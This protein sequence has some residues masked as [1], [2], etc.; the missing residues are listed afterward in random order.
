MKRFHHKFTLPLI[1]TLLVLALAA[2]FIGFFNLRQ[3]TTLPSNSNTSAIGIELNQSFDYV[4][5]HSLQTNGV[6]FVYLRGTQGKSYFDDNYLA[7][8][9]QIQGTK[10][11]YGTQLYFS[12]ESTPREQYEYFIKKIGLDT[13]SL[14]LMIV[15]AVSERNSK[16]LKAMSK[17][18]QMFKQR[19]K[20]VIVALNYRYHRYFPANTQ[21]I[22]DGNM[23]PNKLQ[24]AFWRYTTNGRVKNVSGLEKGVTMFSYNGSVSQYKQKYGQ[25]TQ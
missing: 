13:G 10:L 6:S 21:F 17:L 1:L 19:G 25:L 15:P 9:D 3:Q 14:P 2:L 23:Q 11:A 7:Y 24:Y 4:D 18:V 22:T 20:N 12:N 8:R 5:L 16:Y